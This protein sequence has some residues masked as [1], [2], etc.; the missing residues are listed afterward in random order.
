L[1]AVRLCNVLEGVYKKLFL[2][3]AF[4][5]VVDANG[6]T[7]IMFS[8]ASVAQIRQTEKVRQ[9]SIRRPQTHVSKQGEGGGISSL[10]ADE[11]KTR[12]RSLKYAINQTFLN[13]YII[14][15][16]WYLIQNVCRLDLRFYPYFCPTMPSE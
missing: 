9:R 16:F 14:H 15:S 4:F 11:F 5:R 3:E 13:H 12:L 8:V 1:K 2:L 10:K 7:A 6:R